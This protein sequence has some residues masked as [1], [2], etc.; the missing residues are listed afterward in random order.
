MGMRKTNEEFLKEVHEKNEYVRRG[1]IEI[2]S[3]YIDSKTKIKCRC[4][5]HD[6]IYWVAPSSLL[7]NIG[8]RKCGHERTIAR[9]KKSHQQFV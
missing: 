7:N 8:C 4:T 3:E 6:W 5:I 1:E 9:Q 2:L